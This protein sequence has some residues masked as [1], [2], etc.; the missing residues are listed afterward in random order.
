M[1]SSAASGTSGYMVMLMMWPPDAANH[2]DSARVEKRGPWMTTAVPLGRKVSPAAGERRARDLVQFGVE[3]IRG[4]EMLHRA[5]GG[6]GPVEEGVRA[7]GRAVEELIGEDEG[8]GRVLGGQPAHGRAR[9]D[10]RDAERGESPDVGAVRDQVRRD[11]VVGAVAGE[12]CDVP[13]GEGSDSDQGRAVRRL[14]RA[15]LRGGRVEQSVETGP[16]DDAD[17]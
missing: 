15:R 17:A 11:R 3:R 13:A 12:E 10:R 5:A 8:A 6:G 9:D 7:R 4:R 2:R 14:D 16:A 1:P